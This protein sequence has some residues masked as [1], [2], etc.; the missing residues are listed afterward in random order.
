MRI[1]VVLIA[2]GMVGLVGCGGQEGPQGPAGEPGATGPAGKEGAKGATG[3]TGPMGPAGPA[4]PGVAVS[5][6][7][8][9]ARTRTGEDG[10]KAFEGWYDS[11]L[12]TMCSYGTAADGKERC[13]PTVETAG[14]ILYTDPQCATPV[15][16][17][18]QAC[19]TGYFRRAQQDG[20]PAPVDVFGIGAAA[21]EI[22][23]AVGGQLF[24]QTSG[25]C[26]QQGGMPGWIAFHA[27]ETKPADLV[28]GTA[29]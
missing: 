19:A 28:A 9:K 5:G 1:R 15:F 18:T 29:N 10:S 11:Q 6:S 4:G 20:C 12:D 27:T 14:Q 26:V 3:A 25:G 22:D 24:K 8:L 17:S 13:L 21:P 16:V 2:M 23:P 7:R